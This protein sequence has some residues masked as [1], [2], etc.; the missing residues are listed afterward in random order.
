MERGYM[1]F[2]NVNFPPVPGA[3]VKGTRVVAQGRRPNVNFRVAAQDSPT[4]RRFMWVKGDRQDVATGPGTDVTANMEGW[5]SVTPMRCDL[6][7]HDRLAG[8]AKVLEG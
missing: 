2:Y 1:T 3:D 7:A 8:L 5:I 4:G 6:T